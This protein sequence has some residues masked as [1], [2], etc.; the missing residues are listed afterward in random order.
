MTSTV[1]AAELE[2]GGAPDVISAATASTDGAP[3]PP[4]ENP[5]FSISIHDLIE[6]AR[7]DHGLRG[8]S[9]ATSGGSA[10]YES[11]RRYCTRRLARLRRSRDVKKELSHGPAGGKS[12]STVTAAAAGDEPKQH[13][14]QFT[15]KNKKKG[16]KGKGKSG[17]GGGGGG[18]GGQQSSS[19]K[20]GGGKFA[21]HPRPHPD[22][23]DATQHVHY[24]LVSLFSA[25]RC[26]SH[27]MEIKAAYDDAVR[28]AKR[29]ASKR[30][31][32]GPGDDDGD[33]DDFGMNG[34]ES[35]KKKKKASPA[36]IRR[37]Y[38][39]KLHKAAAYGTELEE[40]TEVSCDDRTAIEARAYAAWTRG[41]LAMEIGNWQVRFGD[42]KMFT[43]MIFPPPPFV[44]ITG[45][46]FNSQRLLFD[47]YDAAL[48]VPFLIL[49]R[50][51]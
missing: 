3:P 23:Y 25:E 31:K 50:M 28:E 26:R 11:Y 40:R 42:E 21:F 16:K 41:T 5:N 48:F 44:D 18:G 46:T 29:L 15:S 43:C 24:S 14:Q 27:A 8:T 30:R 47:A 37:H 38:I 1:G 12:T 39:N 17:A 20:K 36:K 49:D 2:G 19:G 22:P 51:R 32:K 13:Q 10:D 6:S 4:P 45:H 34:G 9:G 7:S 33:D 35:K